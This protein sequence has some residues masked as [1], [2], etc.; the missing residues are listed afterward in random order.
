MQALIKLV[1]GL[2]DENEGG[3]DDGDD[4]DDEESSD[5]S[6]SKFDKKNIIE[7]GK[8]ILPMLVFLV[9]G[10][11]S[12]IG[13][14]ICC[15]CTCCDCCCCCCCKKTKCKIPCFIFTYVFFA[16][17]VAVCIYGLTQANKIFVGLADTECSILKFF[18]QVLYGEMKQELPRWAG[19]RNINDILIRLNSTLNSL[20]GDT[21]DQLDTHYQNIDSKRTSFNTKIQAAGDVLQEQQIIH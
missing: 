5:S 3:D 2:V 13:W 15:F 9:I 17:V 8:R 12:I 4:N 16:L 14:L 10:I 21:Y 19:I 18:D 1:R 6:S 11:L 20:T 7:Y